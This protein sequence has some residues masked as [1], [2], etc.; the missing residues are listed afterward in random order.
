MVAVAPGPDHA[1]DYAA[2]LQRY[3]QH[4][5]VAA[6]LSNPYGVHNVE[7]GGHVYICT[8]PRRPWGDMWPELRNYG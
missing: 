4:V 5:R 8:G 6:T 7:S 1:P 3:F 2:H